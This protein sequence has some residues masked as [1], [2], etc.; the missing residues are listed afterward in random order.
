MLVLH[1]RQ[2]QWINIGKDIRICVN[3]IGRGYV[4][5]GFIAPRDVRVMRDEIGEDKN[6][7]SDFEKDQV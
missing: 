3:E 2:G 4:K 5:L 1:R 6:E 7:R